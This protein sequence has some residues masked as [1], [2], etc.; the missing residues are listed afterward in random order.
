LNSKNIADKSDMSID[1]QIKNLY[2]EFSSQVNS[3]LYNKD[4]SDK[5]DQI[6]SLYESFKDKRTIMLIENIIKRLNN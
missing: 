4:I 3:I 6:G 1:S 2:I 5:I